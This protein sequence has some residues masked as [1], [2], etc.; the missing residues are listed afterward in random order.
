MFPDK[1]FKSKYFIFLILFLLVSV[2]FYRSPH[3]FIYGRFWGEDGTIFFQNALENNLLENFFKIYYP[4]LGYYNLFP[5]I[6]ALIAKNFPIEFSPL[7]NVYMSYLILFYIFILTINSNSY[8]LENKKQKFLFCFL[9]LF[10]SSF[11]PEIWVNSVNAQIY[12]CV[13]SIIIL[14]SKNNNGVIFKLVN[15]IALFIGGF[16]SSYV[17]ILFP[18]F[19]IKYYLTKSKNFLFQAFI[20]L[21]SFLFQLSF[22]IN[23]K[24]SLNMHIDRGKAFLNNFSLEWIDLYYL[25]IFIY[26]VFLKTVFSKKIVLELQVFINYLDINKILLLCIITL[27]FISIVFFLY[28]TTIAISKDKKKLHILYSL[29]FIF[30]SILT[31]NFLV[32]GSYIYG[33]YAA[34]PGFIFSLIVLFLN[35]Q[36]IKKKYLSRI[37]NILLIFIFLSGISQFRPNDYQIQFLDCLDN[38]KSW[39][40][41]IASKEKN[42]ILWPYNFEDKWILKLNK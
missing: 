40:Q 35:F 42:I 14:Y 41:Q 27:I 24:S 9:V 7:V 26:N 21:F 29:F 4:T 12:F 28:K 20:V 23:S 30:I 15:F 36:K 37:L 8:L 38:C 1:L 25:K 34:I 16:S 33:R 39:K 3:I 17:A 6:V 18:F 5:R 22:Y 13:L 32:S 10:C 11:V 19:F 2:S 31:M